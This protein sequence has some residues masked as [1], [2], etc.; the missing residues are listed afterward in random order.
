MAAIEF[1]GLNKEF[2]TPSLSEATAQAAPSS[3]SLER[4]ALL[5][6]VAWRYDN[7]E[8]LNRYTRLSDLV[9]SALNRRVGA[10]EAATSRLAWP[11]SGTPGG[12]ATMGARLVTPVDENASAKSLLSAELRAGAKA[13]TYYK[14]FSN[15]RSA[16]SPTGLAGQDY[17]FAMTQGGETVDIDVSV[18]EGA[19]WGETLQLAAEAINASPL[20][21]Q[22]EV[23]NQPGA[24]NK[25]DFL[26]KTGA[27]LAITT[28][29]ARTAQ[30]IT[31]QD[32]QGRLTKGIGLEAVSAPLGAA[33]LGRHSVRDATPAS[34]STYVS[35]LMN[36]EGT[37]GVT[38]GEHR[39]RLSVGGEAMD[40]PVSV[41]AG[42]TWEELLQRTA[43]SINLTDDRVTARVVEGEMSSGRLEPP[44]QRAVA[45][46]VELDAPKLG[47]RLSVGEYGGPWLD[48]IDGFHDPT[49][50]LPT[51]ATGDERY[52]ASATANGWTE[53]RIYEHDG[54]TSTW[55]ET[56][57][58]ATNAVTDADGRDWF[59]DGS[60]W[61]ATASGT[62]AGALGLNAT[63][64]PGADAT[65]LIDGRGR[66]SASGVFSLDRGRLAVAVD[67][68]AGE[69][70]AVR[71]EEAF[72]RVE[73][74]LAD[75]VGAYNE[76]RTFLMSHADL[77]EAGFT[78]TWRDPVR[79]LD[80]ELSWLGVEETAGSGKLTLDRGALHSALTGDTPRA[81]AAL[82]GDG[83]L[84]PGLDAASAF[85]RTPSLKDHLVQPALL[86]D[87]GPSP[88]VEGDLAERSG[89]QAVVDAATDAPRPSPRPFE[90]YASVLED[91]IR[92]KRESLAAATATGDTGWI[93]G[94]DV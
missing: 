66:T 77:F 91:I 33:A 62:L 39:L 14:Y 89:L 30:D 43:Q 24:Y 60:A 29:P 82:V 83:G 22:A 36:P 44:T 25:V 12:G 11:A 93:L 63:A 86:M 57:P 74:R 5:S 3:P 54:A 26:S 52:V 80:T 15:G 19:T 92:R 84:L 68:P 73:D 20:P 21:A 65:A 51:W 32:T 37:P 4:S 71:V 42:M 90:D 1:Q 48:D 50:G 49:N 46:E 76:L 55:T 38:A 47:Q 61:S 94:G 27:I 41:E 45:L 75:V 2:T 81:Q 23:L 8:R 85:S 28:D 58:A 59:Y 10:L 88:A 7:T 53:G 70:R 87:K 64:A 35:D 78:D 9:V 40:V 16:W 72:G 6:R 56:A 17:T 18:P 34:A 13:S 31:I 67:A 69:A 79:D